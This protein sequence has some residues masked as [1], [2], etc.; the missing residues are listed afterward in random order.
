V[1]ARRPLADAPAQPARLTIRVTDFTAVGAS[2]PPVD[3]VYIALGTTIR[4]AGSQAAFRAVDLDLVVE[5]ARVARERGATALAVVSA[6]GADRGSRAFYS[7]VKGEMEG[8]VASLGYTS[9]VIARPSLL[10]GDRAALGQPVRAGE[11]LAARVAAPLARLL[12]AGVRPI[13]AGDVARAMIDAMTTGRRPGLHVLT[14]AQMQM[15]MR[16]H[17]HRQQNAAD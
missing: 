2:V 17:T 7:R 8:A 4:V 6:L 13:P 16:M 12:P 14:S 3:D 15:H 1:L 11:T 5:I 10:L 9:V